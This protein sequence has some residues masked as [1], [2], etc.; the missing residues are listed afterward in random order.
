MLHFYL[1][2]DKFINVAAENKA[3][4]MRWRVT[5]EAIRG[6]PAKGVDGSYRARVRIPHS[7]PFKPRLG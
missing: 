1:P 2:Y 3:D 7:P 5:Q 4:G 6:S